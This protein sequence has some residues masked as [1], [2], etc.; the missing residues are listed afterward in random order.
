LSA[1]QDLQDLVDRAEQLWP[2]SPERLVDLERWLDDAR[3]LVEGRPADPARGLAARPGLREHETKLR[4]LETR[5]RRPEEDAAVLAAGG[6]DVEDRWWQ[7]QLARLVA[8]LRA[9]QDPE[10]GLFS[11]GVS[12]QHGWGIRRRAAFA[13][14]VRER[15]VDGPEAAA[16][17]AETLAAIRASP[18]YADVAWPGG[19]LRPQL[20]LLPL[21]A[22]PESGLQ[23][24]AHL[25]TGATPRRA[26]DG[27]L[28]LA[29][30]MALVLVLLPGG[31]FWMGAQKDDPIGTNYDLGCAG[32][33]MPVHAVTLAPFFCSKYEMTQ[34]QWERFTGRNPST[35]GP[36]RY[37][38]HWN[39]EGRGW[40]AL[41]PVESVTWSEC[42]RTLGRLGLHLPTEA[43]WEYAARGGRESTFWTGTDVAS[44]AGAANLSD[45]FGIT[46]GNEGWS[47]WEPELDDGHTAHAEVGSYRANPYGLHDVV[48]NV[49]EWC[50][51]FRGPYDL[52]PTPGDGERKVELAAVRVQRGGSFVDRAAFA[53]SAARSGNMP[54][55]PGFQLG[56]RPVGWVAP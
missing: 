1:I 54:D 29:E 24:F 51:D 14:S 32:D 31:T 43:Q 6:T 44:L 23:E 56:V 15:S 47:V 53:R 3:V 28:E 22:D 7:V 9:F 12:A 33:E 25:A 2:A 55:T 11:A 40:T 19:A 48:G 39:R 8:D 13:R 37:F 36:K 52:E 4:E 41:H 27:K 30:D 42:E 17:W 38:E 26:S 18:R 5:A 49:W 10:T 16:L 21:G 20:G 34:G 35:Y 50:R 45:R 46:H